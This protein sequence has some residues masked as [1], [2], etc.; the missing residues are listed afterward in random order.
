MKKGTKTSLSH[1][2]LAASTD[3]GKY[4][5]IPLFSDYCC[6]LLSEMGMP[7]LTRMTARMALACCLCHLFQTK[8]SS[9]WIPSCL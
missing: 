5:W 7:A 6:W 2:L 9:L 4:C 3:P 8:S 1:K